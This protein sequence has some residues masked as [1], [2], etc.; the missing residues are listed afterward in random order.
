[1]TQKIL[2]LQA[3]RSDDP[4]KL[5]EIASFAD[6]AGLPIEAFT[7]YDLLQGPP[8]ISLTRQFDAIMVGGSGEFYVSKR[9]LP[10]FEATLA[11]FRELTATGHP[12]FASCF[13]FHLITIALDGE[14]LY[15]PEGMELGTY[16][17]SL[18]QV[19]KADPLFSQM[20]E[21]FSAQLGR[22]DRATRLPEEA[23]NLASSDLSPYQAFR[24]GTKPIWATQFHP[25][26]SCRENIHR[27]KRY[28][29]AYS[30]V[31]S[32]EEKAEALER[33]K[34]S[35]YP[36]NLIPWFLKLIR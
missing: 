16:T 5:E 17:I 32:D 12:T 11:F 22:Q 28:L 8:K 26:L 1:M 34:D 33:F 21:I 2:M 15:D 24:L 9:N 7:S 36:P 6:K 4:A 19:G 20:P 23:V 3:R 25:E 13:G 18:N 31:L 14:I 27:Y 30:A 29:E 10:N 35:P